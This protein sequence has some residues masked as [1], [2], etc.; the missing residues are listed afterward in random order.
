MKSLKRW[1]K[2]CS[3]GLAAAMTCLSVSVPFATAEEIEEIAEPSAWLPSIVQNEDGEPDYIA[4]AIT[5]LTYYAQTACGIA[6]PMEEDFFTYYDLNQDGSIEVEDAVCFLTMYAR[7]SAGLEAVPPEGWASVTTDISVEEG[8]ETT[9]TE[10]VTEAVEITETTESTEAT[11]PTTES[12]TES[13]TTQT[14]AS[15]TAQ[16]TASTTTKAATTT[17]KAATTTA[18]AATTT[19]KATTTTTTT[20]TEATTTTSMTTVTTTTMATK[21]GIGTGALFEGIDVSVYQGAIDWEA[22]K[23]DGVEFAIIRAGYGKYASQKDKYFDTNMKN[24][25]AAGLPCGAYWFSYAVTV[26]DAIKEA[27][28]FYEVI[29]DYQFEYPVSFDMEAEKQTKLTKDEVSAIIDAFCSRM[30]SYGYY[31][32]LY[33]YASFLNNKVTDDIFEKYDIWVAH[34]NTTKPS[35]DKKYGLWQYSSTG[36]IDGITGNVDLDFVYMD[37]ERIIKNV[38][39]NGF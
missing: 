29:K 38:H 4:D 24:A 9:S 3:V 39:L 33:S 23:A 31:V 6:E 22:A 35:F 8:S 14:T 34:Y 18:T 36:K 7:I 30:E 21:T 37:Y 32:S 2:L 25:Q 16:T 19:K 11:F 12:S 13:T 1:K 28:A 26:E 20:T 17:T 27:D 15:T 5:V 10:T